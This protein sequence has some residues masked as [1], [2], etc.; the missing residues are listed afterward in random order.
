MENIKAPENFD[1]EAFA[2]QA[3]AIY[4]SQKA[5]LETEYKGHYAAV[6]VETGEVFI[7]ETKTQ[8]YYSAL[9]K[10]PNTFFFFIRIGL[11]PIKKRGIYKQKNKTL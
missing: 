9:K 4:D 2:M 10:H 5:D 11:P 8:A 3:K 1:H 6:H 7:G